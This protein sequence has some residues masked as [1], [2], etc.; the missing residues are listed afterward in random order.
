LAD[1]FA[2][3]SVG[4][5]RLCDTGSLG[6]RSAVLFE[7]DGGS[8]LSDVD[9]ADLFPGRGNFEIIDADAIARGF[10]GG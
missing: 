4:L 9:G 3:C 2:V 1:R 10:D 5:G 6:A 7:N 8:E